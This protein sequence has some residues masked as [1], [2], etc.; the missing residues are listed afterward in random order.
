M[1]GDGV[2]EGAI[3][4]ISFTEALRGGGGT[5]RVINAGTTPLRDLRVPYL[6]LGSDGDPVE[7]HHTEDLLLPGERVE[8]DLD[9]YGFYVSDA[10]VLEVTDIHGR[11]WRK[12][13]YGDAVDLGPAGSRPA[14]R[15]WGWMKDRASAARSRLRR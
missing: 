12:P 4:S 7:V 13:L 11:R 14:A 15:V 2:P 6:A 10:F 1:T 9:A 5:L 8:F 3:R